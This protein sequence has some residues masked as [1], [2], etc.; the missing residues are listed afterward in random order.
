M[1][2]KSVE[3]AED[4]P[5]LRPLFEEFYALAKLPGQYDPA[6]EERLWSAIDSGVAAVF[7][8]QSPDGRPLGMIGGMVAPDLFSGVL[9]ASEL[10]W[11]V[12]QACRGGRTA[13]TLFHVFE[14]W[15]KTSGARYV[16]M[17]H[18]THP[19]SD[20]VGRVYRRC[21]Y[22]EVEQVFQKELL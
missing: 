4:L 20:T 21:G 16:R 1:T 10:F 14:T 5:Q 3:S 15:A 2:V 11:F 7:F 19:G 8:A 12:P 13:M 18:L 9:T 6:F 17:M 22:S